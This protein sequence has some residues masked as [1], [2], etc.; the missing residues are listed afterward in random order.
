MKIR[1]STAVILLAC[2]LG[3]VSL[4]FAEN[5]ITIL[6]SG[7]SYASL[8]PC[9]C[10]KD[11]A[12][13]V[14]RR[15]TVI[16][17]IKEKVP[18]VLI[19]ESGGSF[20]GGNYDTNSQTTELD[21]QRTR[22]YMQSLEKMGYDAFL[23]SSEEFNFGDGFLKE[24]QSAYKLNYLSANLKGSFKPYIIKEA[25]GIK[26]AVIGISDAE[27]R[28]KTKITYRDDL[29][30]ILSDTIKDIKIEKK[31][32]LVVVLSYLSDAE[33]IRLLE[34]MQGID[35][36]ISSY[37]PF[38]MAS[39][40]EVNGA[41]LI[42]PAWQVRA[43]TKVDLTFS[44]LEKGVE[45]KLTVDT[46]NAGKQPNSILVAIEN[47]N[48]SQDIKDDSEILG[49]IPGCFKD[50]DCVKPGYVSKCEDASTKK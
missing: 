47:I 29:E 28:N 27:V 38:K 13:G 37:N 3:F 25:A 42:H 17:E 36:L 11:P 10:P 48:L 26:I 16:K 41:I 6:V 14:S 7:Q 31:A 46:K 5:K 39:I 32:D 30:G 35:I 22:Y 1:I 23:V 40:Q 4:S 50:G 33:S 2:F 21:K 45:L 20:A 43:L 24:I 19:L 49:I 44:G 18:N 8:Y 12:G 15:A 34:K 9:S